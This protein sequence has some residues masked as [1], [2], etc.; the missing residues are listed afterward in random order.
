MELIIASLIFSATLL[1]CVSLLAALWLLSQKPL[2]AV[3]LQVAS[4]PNGAII[5]SKRQGVIAR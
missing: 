5:W 3:T 1:I 4:V 2:F